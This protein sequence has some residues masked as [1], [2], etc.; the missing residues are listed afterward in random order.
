MRLLRAMLPES[1][2]NPFN[3]GSYSEADACIVNTP[4]EKQ[5]LTL[6]FAADPANIHVLPNGVEEVF[7]NSAPVQRESWLVC[8]AT[9]TERKRVLELARAAVLAGTPLW[10]VGKPY[11]ATDAYAQRFADWARKHSALVRYEG[12]ITN[13]AR[14]AGLYRSARGFVLLSTMETRSLSAEE[15]AACECPLL[16]SDLPWARSVFGEDAAY[17][18]VTASVKRTAEHLRKFYDT[19]PS[20]KPPAR[21][22]TWIEV[23]Q[24]LKSIY[25]RLLSTSR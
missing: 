18:P 9:I 17:C 20:L 19:A 14:L 21:P 10:V 22:L 24:Q 16:L 1:F 2:T 5:V 6:L 3:W 11:T 25:E 15:A 13:R 4:W 8:T 12:A 23:A 7:L